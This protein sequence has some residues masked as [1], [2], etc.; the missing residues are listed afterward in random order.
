LDLQEELGNRLMCNCDGH[1][2]YVNYLDFHWVGSKF[3]K[4]RSQNKTKMQDPNCIILMFGPLVLGGI[5]RIK[6][7]I[8]KSC[9]RLIVPAFDKGSYNPILAMFKF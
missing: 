5:I 9:C 7:P 4:P 8:T 6:I 3:H 1:N 2:K